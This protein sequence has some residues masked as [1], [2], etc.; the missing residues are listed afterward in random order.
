M[1]LRFVESHGAHE[2]GPE[3]SVRGAICFKSRRRREAG[4]RDPGILE[5]RYETEIK[6]K[7][8]INQLGTIDSAAGND[9]NDTYDSRVQVRGWVCWEANRA[10]HKICNNHR[11]VLRRRLTRTAAAETEDYRRPVVNLVRSDLVLAN[12]PSGIMVRVS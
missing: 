10:D 9:R 1:L 3:A 11:C 7:E 4:E 12:G 6:S 8:Y 2:N 5:F